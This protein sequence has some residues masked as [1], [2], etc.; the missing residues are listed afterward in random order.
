MNTA[1]KIKIVQ[2][3]FGRFEY[4]QWSERINRRYSERHHYEHVISREAPRPDR[5]IV[6]HKIP[7]ILS[8]LHDCDY[9][10]WTDADTLFYSQE[11][12][13][14]HELIPLIEDFSILFPP[15][16]AS[17]TLRWN[18]RLPCSGVMLIRNDPIAREFFEMWN[19]SSDRKKEYLWAW[20]PEQRSLWGEVLPA[21][22]DK[23][24]ILADYYLMNGN[25][26][27]FIRHFPLS[28]DEVRTEA[29]KNFYYQRFGEF[30][31]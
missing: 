1:P 26:S 17:E 10:L 4:F 29:M 23:I 31:S 5:H 22:R 28:T 8:E 20:P 30:K 3:M 9:L 25:Y 15:D 13:I 27:Q 24:K 12:K 18:P 2:Y 11:L 14:E 19:A 21:Y 6:W 16:I 7:V